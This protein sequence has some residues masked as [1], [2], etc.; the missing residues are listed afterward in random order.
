MLIYDHNFDVEDEDIS[1]TSALICIFC[2]LHLENCGFKQKLTSV[3]QLSTYWNRCSSLFSYCLWFTSRWHAKKWT[4]NFLF[5]FILII[6]SV[7]K[8]WGRTNLAI[9]KVHRISILASNLCLI[10]LIFCIFLTVLALQY[11]IL[12]R[13]SESFWDTLNCCCG[14]D[15]WMR[16]ARSVLVPLEENKFV[17]CQML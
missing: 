16:Y 2:I 10:L 11:F 8:Q 7:L 13:A 14:F 3:I 5:Y 17:P 9:L 15:L 1:V 4:L 6:V 12:S